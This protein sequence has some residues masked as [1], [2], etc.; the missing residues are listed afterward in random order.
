MNDKLKSFLMIF[1][2]FF[3]F[4]NL[5]FIFYSNNKYSSSFL[6]DKNLVEN[7]IFISNEKKFK[8]TIQDTI[9]EIPNLVATVEKH[10]N[11]VLNQFLSEGFLC[12]QENHLFIN[13]YQNK[14][15][16]INKS[17]IKSI[18]LQGG[19]FYNRKYIDKVLVKFNH[20]D[21]KN[22]ANKY[23]FHYLNFCFSKSYKTHN[24]VNSY[25]EFIKIEVKKINKNSL[26]DRIEELQ[27]K[28]KVLEN[29]TYLVKPYNTGLNYYYY[30]SLVCFGFTLS[31]LLNSIFFSFFEK[32]TK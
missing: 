13:E 19:Y 20:S 21:S 27:K 9:Q 10:K 32:K 4:L 7:K 11:Y 26:I 30:L 15:K 18:S 16:I 24:I 28:N 1:L 3:I 23:F 12:L 8:K 22:I 5:Y 29:F 31:I 2:L 17:L 14:N 25:L 6:F